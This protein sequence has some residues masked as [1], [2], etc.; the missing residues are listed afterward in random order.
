MHSLHFFHAQWLLTFT[1]NNNQQLK[2]QIKA[3]IADDLELVCHFLPSPGSREQ[4]V[5]KCVYRLRVVGQR[6]KRKI[7]SSK[8]IDE[9]CTPD[10]T[11]QAISRIRKTLS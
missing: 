4:I 3:K 10:S 9:T 8:V 2:V 6:N 1:I 5:F 11:E 7:N